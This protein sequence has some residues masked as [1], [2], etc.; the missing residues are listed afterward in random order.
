MTEKT[1]QVVD[2]A[3]EMA[4]EAVTSP[5][6]A[7]LL[8]GWILSVHWL[9][10]LSDVF[11]WASSL[12]AFCAL[13]LVIGNHWLTRKKLKLEVAALEEKNKPDDPED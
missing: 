11:K 10:L 6:F 3:G 2:V 1:K 5:K 8:S 7:A 12:L 9:E 13:C 4:R